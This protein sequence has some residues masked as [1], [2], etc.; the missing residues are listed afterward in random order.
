MTFLSS[1]ECEITDLQGEAK[2]RSHGP[3][4]SSCFRLRHLSSRTWQGGG[5]CGCLL[6]PALQARGVGGRPAEASGWPQ[7]QQRALCGVGKVSR[8]TALE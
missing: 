8:G 6:L 4:L 5:K 1:G 7:H 2:Q 3:W